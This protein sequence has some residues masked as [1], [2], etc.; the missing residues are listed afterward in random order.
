[1]KNLL[2]IISTIMVLSSCATTKEAKSTRIELKNEKKLA[3][4]AIVEKAVES[5]RFIIKFDKIYLSRGGMIDLLPRSNYIIIDG[6][7]AIISAAYLGRQYDIKPIAG[8]SMQGENNNYELTNNSSGGMT[9]IKMK[10]NNSTNSF[11]VY[12]TISKDGRCNASLS[13]LMI[14]NIRYRGHIVPIKDK[15]AKTDN[16]QQKSIMI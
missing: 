1:M 7:K 9:R 4:Q 5:K 3:N 16:Q 2:I 15:K 13:S 8:I 6:N 12:L 14:D 10:I 11:D